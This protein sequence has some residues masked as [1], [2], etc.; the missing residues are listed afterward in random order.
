MII[1]DGC[2]TDFNETVEQIVKASDL[3]MSIIIVGVGNADFDLMEDLDG[4]IEP[5]YSKNLRRYRDRDIV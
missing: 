4:D 3:P 1:T 2:I 5:L